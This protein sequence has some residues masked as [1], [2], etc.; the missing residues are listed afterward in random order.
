VVL[1]FGVGAGFDDLGVEGDAGNDRGEE[2]R[3]ARPVSRCEVTSR[4]TDVSELWQTY[5]VDR[6][7]AEPTR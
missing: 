2:P 3:V 5:G 1:E 7:A 6:S 4:Y